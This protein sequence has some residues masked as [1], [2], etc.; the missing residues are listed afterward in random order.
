MKAYLTDSVA[1]NPALKTLD[2]SNVFNFDVR[3]LLA[4]INLTSGLIIYASGGTSLGYSSIAGS[5]LTLTY[6]TTAMNA[7]D[8]LQVIYDT[9]G[10]QVDLPTQDQH[11]LPIRPLPQQKFRTTFAKTISGNVDSDYFTLVRT[12]S[13]QAISQASGN[14]VMTSGTTANAE[15]IVRSNKTFKDSFIL[16]W[17]AQLSQRIANN[18]FI[19]ELVDLIGDGLAVTVNSSTSIT[20]TIPDNSFTSE[21]VGQ[22]IYVGNINGVAGIPGRFAIASVSGNN[23]NFTVAGW[24]AS[25]SGNLSLFGW[26]YH[27]IIYTGTS[28]TQA[29][30]DAQRRGWA[31]G[32]TAATMNSSATGHMGIITNEDGASSLMD[33]L[34]ASS[35]AIQTAFRA[36]RVVNLPEQTVPLFI[37]IRMLNG[38]ANPASTTT[39][40]LGTISLE[41]FLSQSVTLHSTKPMGTSSPQPIQVVNTVATTATSTNAAGTN[42]IGDVGHQYR[43]S[44]TGA[45]ARSHLVSGAST[46]ATIVKASAGRLLGWSVANTTASWKYVKLHNSATAPTAGA[47]VV[48]VIQVPPNGLAQFKLEGGIAHSTGI[49]FTTTTGSADADATAVAAGDLIID[50]YYA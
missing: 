24:P 41:N 12:G 10:S 27:Q 5:V 33:Q 18:N 11:Y 32:A 14:L 6:D 7:G 19:V 13:G 31:S 21:N 4:V 29:T 47:G 38:T 39:F 8:K 2:F 25:G 34:V 20:V 36:S 50:L 37:Q 42:L 46:N 40:T 45:A 9:V 16:K 26:N 22:S 44:A 35:T 28:A 48:G 23:V 17:Q 30:Y 1:F 3:K 15:T 43:A 49:S